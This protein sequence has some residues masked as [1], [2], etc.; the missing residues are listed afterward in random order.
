MTSAHVETVSPNTI[1]LGR[2]ADGDLI[3][4]QELGKCLGCSD[5]TLQRM[6]ERFELPPPMTLGG[7]K[8]WI[9]GKVRAWFT[10]AAERRE[11]EALKEARRLH[12][13]D[14]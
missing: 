6:V 11:A 10:D 2:F 12:V 1:S 14:V 4:K 13:F 5:R 8:V 3:T 9:I 7:R